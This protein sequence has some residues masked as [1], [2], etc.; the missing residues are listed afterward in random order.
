MTTSPAPKSI[1]IIGAS[2][3]G[4]ILTLSLL[5]HDLYSPETITVFDVRQRE[6]PDAAN[7]SGVVLTPN[8]LRVLD[9]LGILPRFAHLCWL[10][11]YRT[12]KNDRGDT[13]RKTLIANEQLYGYKNHR[14]WRGVLLQTLLEMVEEKGVM[15]YWGAK[16]D[17][18]LD[19][20][21]PGVRF[22]V[23]G[24]EKLAGMLIGADGIYSSV[25]KYIDPQI[26]PEYTGVVGVLSHIRWDAVPWPST[27][28]ER[29]CT[30]QGKP[31]ALVLMPED[32]EGN[33]IMVA[34][35]AKMEDRSREEWL[36]MAKDKAGMARFFQRGYEDW[37]PTGRHIIDAVCRSP[38]T[39]Y[40]WPFM[41]MARQDRW[42]S[43]KG[44]VVILGDAAHALPPSSGQGVSQ[45]LED[46]DAL[47]RLLKAR[48]RNLACTLRFWQRIRQD[49]IDAV[50]DW[51]T[52]VTNV[53]G[54]P[55]ADRDLLVQQGKAKDANTTQGF[56]DMA[57]LYRPNVDEVIDSWLR[58]ETPD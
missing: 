16:F 21:V 49:R 14:V 10:S 25:R 31:G 18:V 40:L 32:R 24:E 30:I 39:M 29:A 41:R 22:R 47:S 9:Q 45:T 33:V 44:L 11:D 4:L 26:Q 2:L 42:A 3:T 48:P 50:F 35:Q 19:E 28:H 7:S 34:T 27:D 58:R 15:I 53:Q 8:G 52:N 46:V 23:N 51:A 54:A 38:D 56:D 1:A 43:E 12:Y 36:E 20:G 17:Q 37:G 57:W 6:T 55:Q 5:H 13:L